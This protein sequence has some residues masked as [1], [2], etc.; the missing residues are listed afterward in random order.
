[1]AKFHGVIGFSTFVETAPGVHQA[2]ITE[3]VYS[4]DVLREAV[5]MVPSSQNLNDNAVISSRVSIIADP[6]ALENVAAIKYV[7]MHGVKWRVTNWEHSF[8]RL[9]LRLGEVYNG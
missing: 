4:G 2:Q 6:F 8:P 9:I 1:M 3:V 7:V 5:Q